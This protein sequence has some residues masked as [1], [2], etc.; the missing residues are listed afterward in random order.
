MEKFRAT[1][2]EFEAFVTAKL[3]K[4]IKQYE[5][6][7]A[8]KEKHMSSL[9]GDILDVHYNKI[10]FIEK[11]SVLDM[12]SIV[13]MLGKFGYTVQI[14]ITKTGSDVERETAQY[15]A[16]KV[17]EFINMVEKEVVN[18]LR[19]EKKVEF[20]QE[21]I[22]PRK[23]LEEFIKLETTPT[24][25]DTVKTV[26]KNSEEKQL[27]KRGRKK[28]NRNK[29]KDIVESVI[30]GVDN[31]VDEPVEQDTEFTLTEID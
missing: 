22:D 18:K 16:N 1:P 29:A 9:L 28:Q 6:E 27:S 21:K 15:T 11:L 8:E 30:N 20:K 23:L 14:C 7:A 12:E 4:I 31:T 17:N 24:D 13:N 2:V 19:E 5:K 25:E 3:Y 10:K 26:S